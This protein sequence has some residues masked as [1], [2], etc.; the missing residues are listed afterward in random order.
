MRCYFMRDGRIAAVELLDV[1]S[2]E[3]AIQHAK[4]SSRNGNPNSKASRFGTGRA[5]SLTVHLVKTTHT[6]MAREAAEDSP[7]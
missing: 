1:K 3:E 4:H 6:R 5:K 7:L 2:D